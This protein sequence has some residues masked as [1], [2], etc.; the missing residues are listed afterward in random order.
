[1]VNVGRGNRFLIQIRK[2]TK[3]LSHVRGVCTFKYLD[4]ILANSLIKQYHS[5]T[6]RIVFRGNRCYLQAM[7]TINRNI[8]DCKTRSCYGT[9]GLDFNAGFIELAETN[10]IGNLIKLKHFDLKFHGTGNKAENEIRNVVSEIVDYA[11][12]VG[13]DIVIEDLDFRKARAE[14]DEAKSDK[15]K[16]Y[17]KMIHTFDYSR[18]KKTFESCCFRHDVCL[19]KIN[20]AYTSKIAKQKYCDKKKLTVHQGASYVIARKGQGYVDKYN[21][22]RES[23]KIA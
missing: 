11:I 9:I 1:M 10:E 19:I 21:K 23:K 18:Y 12:S 3:E 17:N 2:N 7:I 15:G 20:P 16:E 8:N 6:Y 13:K 22:T 4:G 14:T 5:V